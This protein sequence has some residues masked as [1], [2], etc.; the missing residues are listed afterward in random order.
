M[1]RRMSFTGPGRPRFPRRPCSIIHPS[2]LPSSDNGKSYSVRIRTAARTDTSDLECTGRTGP[3][4]RP[5]R[6]Q[7][8]TGKRRPGG[9]A[10]RRHTGMRHRALLSLDRSRAAASPGRLRD[11]ALQQPI[12]RPNPDRRYGGGITVDMASQYLFRIM[13]QRHGHTYLPALLSLFSRQKG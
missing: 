1:I 6:L 3:G 8:C 12:R 10:P 11:C 13:E 9:P 2:K 4:G 7:C 5:S